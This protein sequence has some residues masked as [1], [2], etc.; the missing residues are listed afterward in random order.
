[1]KEIWKDIEGYEGYYQISNLGNIKSLN[2]YVTAGIGLKFLPSQPIKTRIGKDKCV[3]VSLNKNYTKKTYYVARLVYK[4][5]NP[6]FDINDESIVVSFKDNDTA[7]VNFDNLYINERIGYLMP[8]P[9]PKRPVICITSNKRFNSITE[10]SQFYRVDGGSISACC[11]SKSRSA[12][13]I[14]LD[15]G[16]EYKLIWRYL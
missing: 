14:I 15:D 16:T 10:A 1:M 6:D 13:K 2:R 11:K 12:G 5:F 8:P 9:E 4:A 3:K 7:N